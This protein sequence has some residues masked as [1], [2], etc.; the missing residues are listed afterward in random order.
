M[1]FTYNDL[2]AEAAKIL[3][4]AKKK[5]MEE[6]KAGHGPIKPR[7][8][9]TPERTA[10]Y[11][12]RNTS[13]VSTMFSVSFPGQQTKF[14]RLVIEIFWQAVVHTSEDAGC[15]TIEEMIII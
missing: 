2:A 13:P 15:V 14:P 5:M 8:I 6:E 9:H 3:Y 4:E 1:G 12:F 11:E 10:R 7:I